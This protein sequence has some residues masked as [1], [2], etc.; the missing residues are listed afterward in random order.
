MMTFFVW[1]WYLY[2]MHL[3]PFSSLSPFLPS[4]CFSFPFPFEEDLPASS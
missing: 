3:N 4:L 2:T 1:S